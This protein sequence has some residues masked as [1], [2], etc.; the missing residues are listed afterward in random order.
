MDDLIHDR[1]AKLAAFQQEIDT[2]TE[3]L[4]NN[5][6]EKEYLS[7][8]LT[9]FK[10]DS[11]KESKYIDKEIVLEEQNKVLENIICKMY[12]ST[13][14]MHM[15]TKPQVFYD[16]THKQAL[17]YQNPFHL[18][19]AQRMQ[20]T[21]YDGSIIAKEHAVIFII[22]DEETLILEEESRS[23]MLDK[24]ND[25]IS[26][27]KKIKISPND[28]SKLNK[29]KEDFAP[30]ELPKVSLV[31]ESLKKL[32]YQLAN[33]DNV[34]KKSLTSD[35]ITVGSWGFEHIKECFVTEIVP[36]L[37][38]LKDTINEFDKTLLDEITDVQTVFNQMEVAVDQCSV[39]KNAFE[40]Q[41]KQLSIDNDQLLKQ[42]MSQG[43]YRIMSTLEYIYLIII[44][45][46]SNV[47]DA[48]SSTNT[49]DYTPASPNYSP[50]LPGN[51]SSPAIS[52]F[53]DDP[54]MKVMQAYNATNDESPIPPP[55]APIAPLTILPP[56]KRARFLS[57]FSTDS[58]APPQREQIRHVDEI[59]L[60]CVRIST[61]EMVIEDIQVTMALLPPGFLEHL[62]LD[63]INA[64]DIERMIPPTPPRDIKPPVGSPISLSPSPI[65]TTTSA[66]PAMT[67]AA[68]P[69]K[70]VVDSVAQLWKD[71]L[72]PWQIL[73]IPIGIPDK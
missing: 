67:Q 50:A 70:L 47:E 66:A 23:K 34:V 20:P 21:L 36:F 8:T 24:Q 54:Y 44:L 1:N 4:S 31:N 19:K 49:P 57:P 6:K 42:I 35:A 13:Q 30:S 52:P 39:D 62:Y 9:I 18:K 56:Q 14:V 73:I 65:Q 17:G 5:V 60:A 3:T 72:L 46:D 25:L 12:R 7:K 37:K 2:L 29:I 26:I 68:M 41:I 51:T 43:C 16:D 71:K 38:V 53:H 32:T 28:Y 22:D 69:R 55:R 64:Q 10:T 48:F 15:L 40:I 33:Y 45:F 27:E 58:S 59:V 11:K 61:L 63:M